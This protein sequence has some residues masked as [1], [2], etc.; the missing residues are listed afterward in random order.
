MV[1]AWGGGGS[2]VLGAGGLGLEMP[3]GGASGEVT[4]R[5]GSGAGA[6]LR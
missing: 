2:P 1:F 6:P 3:Q 4:V 5:G